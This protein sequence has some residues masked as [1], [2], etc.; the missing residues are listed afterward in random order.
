MKRPLFWHQGVFLQPQHFQWQDLHFQSLLEPFYGLMAP[1]FWGVEDLDIPRGALENS[2][3]EIQKGRFLFSDMTYVT[4]PGN[5]SIEPRSFDDTRLEGGKP[6]TVY[7]GLR[8]WKDK[9]EN[10]TV[11]SSLK[12]LTQV[13]TRFVA[14][15]D[16]ENIPDMHRG[17]PNKAQV[18]PLYHVLKIFWDTEIR[19]LGDYEV[20]PVARL[21]RD[22]EHIVL[23][24]R[25]SPPCLSVSGSTPLIKLVRDIRDQMAARAHHL[26]IYKRKRGIHTAEFGS[27]DMVYL[28]TLMSLNRYVPL[29]FHLTEASPVHPWNIYGVLRQIVG[30]LSSFSERV[31]VR[32]ESEDGT[33]LV[34][35]Y[36]HRNLWK[37][38][39]DT[40]A[41]IIRLLG[42][43]TAGPD[44]VIRL[45]W[46]GTYY[47]A[48]MKPAV[49]EGQNRFYLVLKT[50][51]DPI[52]VIQSLDTVAKLGSRE[53][54]PILIARALSGIP[55]EH[56][57]TPPPELPYRGGSV[58]FKI[59]RH[60]DLW[61]DVE[62]RN[63]IVLYWDTAPDDLKAEIMIVGGA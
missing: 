54:M 25:F 62:K 39:S 30:E 38:F 3:F 15:D 5:A 48:D 1:H 27:R 21:D 4:F 44:Y 14:R 23:S 8:K 35:D 9:G 51:K 28:L 16:P 32:G 36:D 42:E 46:D 50:D 49:L 41:Q 22:R 37:C 29:L 2:S 47:A 59:D 13:T 43:I 52:S 12:D 19:D 7:V 45:A 17:G 53:Q 33:R 31:S 24:E 57:S 6:L 55:L 18:K 56:L 58:Y 63:N 34:P 40:N 11:L 61:A 20:I 26:E 10:V 60:S